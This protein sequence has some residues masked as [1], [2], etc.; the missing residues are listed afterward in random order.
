M[1]TL[2]EYEILKYKIGKFKFCCLLNTM[3]VSAFKLIIGWN[4]DSV[5]YGRFC[6][7]NCQI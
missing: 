6:E 5:I 7:K 2:I 1:L 4:L 3:L